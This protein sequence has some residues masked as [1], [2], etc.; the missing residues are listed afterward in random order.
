MCPWPKGGHINGS[1]TLTAPFY[2]GCQ[3]A[4]EL[5]GALIAERGVGDVDP[6]VCEA[7]KGPLCI[8]PG[9]FAVAVGTAGRVVRLASADRS[10]ALLRA[11][12]AA[13]EGCRSGRAEECARGRVDVQQGVMLARSVIGAARLS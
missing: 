12:T 9:A 6:A 7:S 2:V 3:G 11:W 8:L 1:L 4:A 10:R 13:N 5:I